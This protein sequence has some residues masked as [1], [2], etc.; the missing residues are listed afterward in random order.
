MPARPPF[1]VLRAAYLRLHPRY[2][3]EVAL[4]RGAGIKPP[5]SYKQID[6]TYP[7]AYE[8]A[9]ENL[10]AEVEQMQHEQGTTCTDA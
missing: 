2:Y 5:P 6:R 8:A 10:A 4:A 9:R 7:G 1:A 3:L